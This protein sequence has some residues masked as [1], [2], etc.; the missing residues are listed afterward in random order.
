VL[1][2]R[3][4]PRLEWLVDLGYLSKDGFARN[5]F[6]YRTDTSLGAL[7]ATLE[8][9]ALDEAAEDA[10]ALSYWRSHEQWRPARMSLATCSGDGRFLNAYR[11]LRRSIG[12]LPLRDVGF[13][14]DLISLDAPVDTQEELKDFAKSTPGVSL[15]GGRTGRSPVN[16]YIEARVLD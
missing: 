13:V 12:P 8:A 5:G 15:S 10:V 11:I 1:E 3:V 14:A 2:H 6:E 16:I 9:H 7:A 4:A